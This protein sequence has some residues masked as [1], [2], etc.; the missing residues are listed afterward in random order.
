MAATASPQRVKTDGTLAVI[1]HPA[2]AQLLWE[3]LEN[4]QRGLIMVVASAND[5]RLVR[6]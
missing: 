5:A 4:A 6:L 3:V 2:G 1:Q